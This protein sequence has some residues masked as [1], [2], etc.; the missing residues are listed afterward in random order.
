MKTWLKGVDAVWE[1][2]SGDREVEETTMYI[3]PSSRIEHIQGISKLLQ[4]SNINLSNNHISNLSNLRD[5]PNLH[6]LNM[7]RNKLTT[8]DNIKELVHCKVNWFLY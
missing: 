6:T 1:D 8:A 5:L 2:E 4:L 7:A 3:E